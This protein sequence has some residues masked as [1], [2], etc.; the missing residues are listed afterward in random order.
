MMVWACGV[1]YISKQES[2]EKELF[3]RVPT[4][5]P[6][7]H[8]FLRC[9]LH[10]TFYGEWLKKRKVL[11]LHFLKCVAGRCRDGENLLPDVRRV[12]TTSIFLW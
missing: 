11:E 4:R 7:D 10:A 5:P 2:T 3:P 12:V 8:E 1:I 9:R 6:P